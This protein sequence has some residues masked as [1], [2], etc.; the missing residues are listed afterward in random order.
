M[1][2]DTP[3]HV[4]FI[5]LG[6]LDRSSA[7]PWLTLGT[8]R[9]L[10]ARGIDMVDAPVSGAQWSA[11]SAELVFMVGGADDDVERVRPLL[12]LLGRATYHVGP[13]GSGHVMKSI[14][15]AIT[16]MTFLAT[17]EGPVLG[18]RA[19]LDPAAMNAVLNESTGGSWITRTGVHITRGGAASK[20]CGKGH[21]EK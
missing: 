5:G 6:V 2:S 1:N 3:P 18:T 17:A 4:G 14:N 9:A 8:A 21:D 19:G 13:I 7:Q 12:D 15:N 10:A 11:E 20:W 16:A